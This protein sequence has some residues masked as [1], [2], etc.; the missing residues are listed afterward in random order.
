MN[1][2]SNPEDFTNAAWA[3]SNSAVVANAIEAPDGTITADR[4][5]DQNL[6][7]SGS[8]S[9]GQFVTVAPSTQHVLSI[10]LKPGSLDWA[11]LTTILFTT[12]ANSWG[13]F[14]IAN[15]LQ[16][17]I[18]A[19]FNG[20]GIEEFPDGWCRAFV[21]FI[22][23]AVDVS[24]S[25]NV[26]LAEADGNIT[27]LRDGTHSIYAWGA[28]LE[29]GSVPS[30]YVSEAG[31]S[32]VSGQAPAYLDLTRRRADQMR[33]KQRMPAPRKTLRGKFE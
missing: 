27:F 30:T 5:D 26:Y 23:D 11:T 21:A 4:I 14:D 16:G 29:E 6:A 20:A 3:K 25:G 22:T 19:A 8:A 15:C 10:F 17:T 24:G 18:P 12:P 33:L 13:Y 28:V 32:V 31:I 1:L 2:F 7:T 9:I